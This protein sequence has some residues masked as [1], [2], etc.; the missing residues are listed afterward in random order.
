MKGFVLFVLI[1]AT[2]LALGLGLIQALTRDADLEAQKQAQELQ[3][4]QEPLA[5]DLERERALQPWKQAFL[6]GLMAVTLLSLAGLGYGLTRLLLR[7][8]STV[9][10]NEH[11][12][13]PVL[14]GRVGGVEYA[15]GP[16]RSPT[17]VTIFAPLTPQWGERGV[18]PPCR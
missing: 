5:L 9:Y 16:N 14:R 17:P 13:Y 1:I 4:L 18:P 6:I 12:I 11:G 10:P 8:A 2:I 15:F 7:R 3:A